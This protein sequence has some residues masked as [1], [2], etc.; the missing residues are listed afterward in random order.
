MAQAP[1][2]HDPEPIAFGDSPMSKRGIGRDPGAQQRR[3]AFRRQSGRNSE[4]IVLIH[5]Y[6]I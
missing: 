4:D 6:L 1:E 2:P 3:G 5:D